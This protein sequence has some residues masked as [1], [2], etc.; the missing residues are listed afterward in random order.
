MWISL[1]GMQENPL[2][3]VAQEVPLFVALNKVV[4]ETFAYNMYEHIMP[5]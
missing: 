4:R 3:S 2:L 1:S 5:L